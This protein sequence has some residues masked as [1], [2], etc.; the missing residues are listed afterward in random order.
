M[1]ARIKFAL[2]GA[3]AFLLFAGAGW[4]LGSATG[5]SG[6]VRIVRA[7]PE[8]RAAPKPDAA[9]A[10]PAIDVATF[11]V[12]AAA[13]PSLDPPPATE[14][15]APTSTPPAAPA[16]TTPPVMRPSLDAP[17]RAAVL[18]APEAPDLPDDQVE[19]RTGSDT[20]GDDLAETEATPPGVESDPAARPTTTDAPVG[21]AT[22]DTEADAE[23]E[24]TA[25]PSAEAP[26][27]G[28]PPGM[29]D[30]CAGDHPLE[31]CP[32]GVG[33]TVRLAY[34]SFGISQVKP[35][36]DSHCVGVEAGRDRYVLTIIS[37]LPGTF[38]VTQTSPFHEDSVV[39]TAE[40]SGAETARWEANPEGTEVQTCLELPAAEGD[41]NLTIRI[42]GTS[43]V[44]PAAPEATFM[45]MVS[46]ATTSRPAVL[47]QRVSDRSARLFVG[48]RADE[49]VKAV[50]V[51]RPDGQ[52]TSACDSVT[53]GDLATRPDV[54]VL[55]EAGSAQGATFPP[56]AGS[57]Y[58]SA[59]M[60]MLRKLDP[61]QW[62]VCLTWLR[63]VQPSPIV[64]QRSSYALQM[65]ATPSLRIDAIGMP[66]SDARD[67]LLVQPESLRGV[68]VEVFDANGDSRCYQWVERPL[69]GDA[70]VCET[71]TTHAPLNNLTVRL[72]PRFNDPG[73][74]NDAEPTSQWL[75]AQQTACG[76]DGTCGG[77][78]YMP[79]NGP[80]DRGGEWIAAR[81]KIRITYTD[82]EIPVGGA[83]TLDPS[84]SFGGLEDP[85][86]AEPV[87]PRLD[88][89]RTS[90]SIHETDPF[91]VV[92]HWASDRNAK[93]RVFAKTVNPLEKSCRSERAPGEVKMSGLGN[94]SN[95][96]DF[97]FEVCP[98]V[99]YQ[100]AIR[101]EA[102][103]QVSWFLGGSFPEATDGVMMSWPG[104][105]FRT[106]PLD[107]EIQYGAKL[108]LGDF[109]GYTLLPPSDHP[110]RNMHVDWWSEVGEHEF[111]QSRLS[112]LFERNSPTCGDLPNFDLAPSTITPTPLRVTA[113]STFRIRVEASYT[114]F[115][116]CQL[117]GAGVNSTGGSGFVNYFDVPVYD[118]THTEALEMTDHGYPPSVDGEA[119]ASCGRCVPWLTTTVL[120]L[121]VV[122]P[123][124]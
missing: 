102:D 103:E 105:R 26:E 117:T 123:T 82:P 104:G 90:I 43:T 73:G 62:D 110:I 42:R 118:L 80:V 96:G 51:K 19:L 31:G 68:G 12:L 60:Y 14:P 83:W 87:V 39:R 113:G 115:E 16:A 50:L 67:R 17:T 23:V 77:I 61:V 22:P 98:G 30:L 9:K 34:S 66:L 75:D 71:D 101:L 58:P 63:N 111:S 33:A 86:A 78:A 109:T 5:A 49:T 37:N 46:P 92:V 107:L 122:R 38:T 53:G 69:T 32:P 21:T 84:G 76:G 114:H 99:D 7:A 112:G 119:V 4:A 79:I 3:A 97:V 94:L 57:D 89:S 124:T 2:L 20:D 74:R 56:F 81:L 13:R 25:D 27:G 10:L 121:Q 72:T 116:R 52:P 6:G 54:R 108:R 18:A 8:D 40:T 44:D 1:K 91:K 29:F 28:S 35:F 24:P 120:N 70:L 45:T 88:L 36:A 48:S 95:N 100:F 15:G 11:D 64:R 93:A 55:A 85:G 59:R 41:Q 106:E 65:P 47:L